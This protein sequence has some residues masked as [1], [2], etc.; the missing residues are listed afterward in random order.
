MAELVQVFPLN[1]IKFNFNNEVKQLVHQNTMGL[2]RLCEEFVRS[3]PVGGK[4]SKYA[5]NL[6]IRQ[7]A[8]KSK[9][10]NEKRSKWIVNEDVLNRFT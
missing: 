4:I 1:D 9:L 5:T 8:Q 6:K 7:I 10:T 3:L 2:D